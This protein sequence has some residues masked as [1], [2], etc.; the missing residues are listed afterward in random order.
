[1]GKKLLLRLLILFISLPLF[2]QQTNTNIPVSDIEYQAL[3]DFYKAMGESNWSNKWNTKENN[4]HEVAWYGVTT[5]NGHITAINLN[6][7]SNITGI[8][9]A[10]FGNLKHL[11]SLS[12]YGRDYPKDLSNS[13]LG[14]L[15]DLENLEF[16]DLSLIHI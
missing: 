2:A 11:K 8:I 10:S 3:V 5:E 6:N 1:M 15:S 7:T 9:P 12:L 14:V 4:L 16:L 13:D